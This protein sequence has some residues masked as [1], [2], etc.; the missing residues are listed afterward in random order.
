ML[1]VLTKIFV[2]QRKDKYL[3]LSSAL[4]DKLVEYIGKDK[5]IL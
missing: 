5:K 1:H 4:F 2:L 3:L